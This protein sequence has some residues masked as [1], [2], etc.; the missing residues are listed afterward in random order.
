M[1]LCVSV[2]HFFLLLSIISWYVGTKVYLW[3]RLDTGL[4]P[5]WRNTNHLCFCVNIIFSFIWVNIQDEGM[6]NL[7]KNHKTISK[8]LCHSTLHQQCRLPSALHPHKHM[9]L[10]FLTILIDFWWY[11]TGVLI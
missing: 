11:L 1:L 9:I 10:L 7:T 2:V 4:F 5:V 6:L 8:V 3:P